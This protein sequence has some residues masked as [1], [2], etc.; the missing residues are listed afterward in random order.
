MHTRAPVDVFFVSALG[1]SK[2]TRS[3]SQS[4]VYILPVALMVST[5]FESPLTPYWK[6]RARILYRLHITLE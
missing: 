3:F 6:N 5:I 2:A 1:M 4:L